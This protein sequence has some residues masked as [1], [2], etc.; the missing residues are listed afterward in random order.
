MI[1]DTRLSNMKIF[2]KSIFFFE[3]KPTYK[4]DHQPYRGATRQLEYWVSELGSILTSEFA[5]CPFRDSNNSPIKKISPKTTPTKSLKRKE[6]NE[7]S[8]ITPL[9]RKTVKR[10]ILISSYLELTTSN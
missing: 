10:T 8:F 7:N 3:D 5:S 2:E 6:I 4:M 9:Q 1:K